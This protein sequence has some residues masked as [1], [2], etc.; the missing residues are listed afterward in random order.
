MSWAV[1][2]WILLD[3]KKSH[4]AHMNYMNLFVIWIGKGVRFASGGGRGGKYILVL[5][6]K[7]HAP[8]SAF[9]WNT[10]TSSL[11]NLKFGVINGF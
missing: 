4:T 7:Y 10:V 3:T 2:L 6:G 11:I 8:G 9:S 5:K 1:W